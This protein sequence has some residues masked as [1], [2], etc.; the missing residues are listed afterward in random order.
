MLRPELIAEL[1]R[2]RKEQQRRQEERNRPF[3]YMP[4]PELE[5]D[6]TAERKETDKKK[7]PKS[8]VIVIEF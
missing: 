1:E 6:E 5:Q 8:T 3:L 2:L 7:E 4:L